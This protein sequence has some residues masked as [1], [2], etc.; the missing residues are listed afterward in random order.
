MESKKITLSDIAKIAG[1]TIGTVDRAMHNR[2][3]IS[4]E[5][6][7][8]ILEIAKKYNYRPDLIG[9]SL[10]SPFLCRLSM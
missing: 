3:G 6:R 10:S 8:R 4:E 7:K 5:T 1:V 9:R 2:P